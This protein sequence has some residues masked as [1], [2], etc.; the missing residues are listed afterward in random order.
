MPA[1]ECE[2]RLGE[3]PLCEQWQLELLHSLYERQEIAISAQ[4]VRGAALVRG[5]LEASAAGRPPPGR[6][7]PGRP[8]AHAAEEA[9]SRGVTLLVRVLRIWAPEAREGASGAAL[10]AAAAA[11]KAR[12]NSLYAAGYF[13][14]AMRKYLRALWLLQNGDAVERL[15]APMR[16]A[17]G[18][19]EGRCRFGQAEAAELQAP[20][21]LLL[22]PPGS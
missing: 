21:R 10:L 13:A 19:G 18:I 16:D 15:D 4:G 8:P 12:A 14:G 5:L 11:L 17:V 6:P 3:T 9:L 2:L 7:P 1:C 22:T 20:T